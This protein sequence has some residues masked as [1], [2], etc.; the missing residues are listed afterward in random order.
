MNNEFSLSSG[1]AHELELM[2]RK[3]GWSNADVKKLCSQTTMQGVLQ[4][5]RGNADFVVRK[6]VIDNRETYGLTSGSQERVV[7]HYRL[8]RDGQFEWNPVTVALH[9]SSEKSEDNLIDA[10]RLYNEMRFKAPLNMHILLYLLNH[11]TLI[12][13]EWQPKRDGD[14]RVIC[15]WGTIIERSYPMD[16]KSNHRIVHSMVWSEE[17]HTWTMGAYSLE[18]SQGE[19]SWIPKNTAS[20]YFKGFAGCIP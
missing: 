10:E 4:F 7:D 16:P 6:H 20:A 18:K 11:Q 15:F 3:T 5:V 19:K 8:G 12:P 13:S 1:Q 2:F 9:V 17:G 14:P